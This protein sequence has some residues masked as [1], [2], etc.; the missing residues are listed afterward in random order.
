VVVLKIQ[1]TIYRLQY[2]SKIPKMSQKRLNPNL[3]FTTRFFFKEKF[4][5]VF[6]G[7]EPLSWS[8]V[9]TVV[10]LNFEAALEETPRKN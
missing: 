8:R 9:P 2:Q 6:R 7:F 3:F 1:I 4:A 5:A 10:C